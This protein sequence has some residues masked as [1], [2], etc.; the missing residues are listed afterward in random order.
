MEKRKTWVVG[1]TL[2]S[3]G[4]SRNEDFE[5][6]H[7]PGDSPEDACIKLLPHL[8][9]PLRR[10]RP[11]IFA[12][13]NETI[14]KAEL[15]V[16]SIILSTNEFGDFSKCT[17]ISELLDDLALM[18]LGN[19]VPELWHEFIHQPQTGRCL[20]FFLILGRLCQEIA[21][22]YKETINWFVRIINLDVSYTCL[23]HIWF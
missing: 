21:R 5:E 10:S 11:K 6:I 23:K 22:E 7:D 3:W 17:I 9:E 15:K 20:V 18:K 14:A 1:I 4:F 16:T 19:K 8:M 12:L 2:R 13:E